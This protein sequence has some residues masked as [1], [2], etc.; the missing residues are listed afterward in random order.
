MCAMGC[1]LSK[2]WR[3]LS[4]RA[5]CT[6]TRA[7]FLRWW[8]GSS[9]PSPALSLN[10]SSGSGGGGG[11]DGGGGGSKRVLYEHFDVR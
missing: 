2:P 3:P 5:P 7:R 4:R 6:P 9:H 8:L 10:I 1:R 11:S